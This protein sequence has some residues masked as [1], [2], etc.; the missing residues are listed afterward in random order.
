MTNFKFYPKKVFLSLFIFGFV[1]L[2]AKIIFSDFLTVSD[3]IKNAS[4]EIELAGVAP[5]PM[6]TD[7]LG[8]TG[9]DVLLNLYRNSAKREEVIAFFSKVTGSSS[10]AQIILRNADKNDI[11][12]ALAFAVAREES[13]FKPRAVNINAGGSIDRGLFQLNNLTFPKL[14][15]KDFFDP[16]TNAYYGLTYLRYC[17]DLS[18]NKVSALAMYNAGTG[19]VRNN[20]TPYITLTYISKVLDYSAGLERDFLSQLR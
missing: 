12:P 6:S 10:V 13:K 4:E 19:K 3:T 15:E 9:E 5:M 20:R 18:G 17:L 2:C 7:N 8:K 16:E 11:P 1:L 14:G